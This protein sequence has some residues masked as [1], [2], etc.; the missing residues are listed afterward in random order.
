M[1]WTSYHATHYRRGQVDRKAECDAYFMEGLNTGYYSVLKSAM[2]GSVYYAAVMNLKRYGKEQPDGTR[3]I[4]DIPEAERRV[5][6]IVFLTA[7]DRK[8]YHNF[9]YKDISEDMGPSESKCPESIL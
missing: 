1:G 3:A 2:V 9:S 6:G 4:E 8:R 5:W 7:V